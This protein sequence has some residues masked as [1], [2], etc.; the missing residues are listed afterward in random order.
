[1]KTNRAVRWL[2]LV[3]CGTAAMK[4]AA[5]GFRVP[6]QDA[7]AA[8]RGEAFVATA[9]NPSAI[10]YNP[11]GLTQLTNTT[12]R[13]GLN[14]L[15]LHTDF[16]PP[17]S[18]PNAGTTYHVA[19]H[20]AAAPQFFLSH[21]LEKIPLSVGLGAYAPYGGS[22]NWPGDTG[23]NAVAEKGA[24]TY[25]RF[26]PVVAFQILPSLSIAAGALVDY[27]NLDLEQGLRANPSRFKNY[28]RFTGDGWSA[29]YNAGVLWRPLEKLS[30]GATFRS[31][32]SFQ[33][34]GK[35]RFELQPLPALSAPTQRTASADVDFP[36]TVAAGISFRP[37][38]KW[39]FEFDADYTDWS[40]FGTI[41]IHQNAPPRPFD[42]D[43]PVVLGW[44]P[45]W[46]Y[47]F[48]VT[49]YFDHGWHASAGYV[50][51]ENS[52]PDARYT[53]LAADMD[54]HFFSIGIGRTGKKFDF[55][56]TYQFGYGPNHPV[57]GSQASSKPADF[58]NQNADGTYSFISHA[59]LVSVGMHF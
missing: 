53:P 5:N 8:A 30:L 37:T 57:T 16:Q 11:A 58:A 54:R 42:E 31:K 25:F 2:G 9:D 56:I 39:N 6:S 36:M 27:A 20:L 4:S 35:T 43:L 55:D 10:Y 3:C 48:G 47:E 51:S 12:L 52:V 26:S 32:T 49:R 38:P 24:L 44:R 28:F 15:Y 34:D 50:F 19:D 13:G 22:I 21:T 23:F 29:G 45:S 7:A 1:M 59:V 33:L 14:G 40:S 17:A 41:V 18:A 46:M